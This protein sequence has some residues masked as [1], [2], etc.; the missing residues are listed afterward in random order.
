MP[1]FSGCRGRR[2]VC[3]VVAIRVFGRVCVVALVGVQGDGIFQPLRYVLADVGSVSL[4]AYRARRFRHVRVVLG[5]Q[6]DRFLLFD[7]YSLPNSL[8]SDL[9]VAFHPLGSLARKAL[10]EV[11]TDRVSVFAVFG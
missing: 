2:L 8:V 7:A 5:E 9:D 6:V 1:P 10:S 11:P 4:F 3:D